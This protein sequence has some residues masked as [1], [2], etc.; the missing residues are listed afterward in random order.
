MLRETHT[1]F[2]SEDFQGNKTLQHL[3]TDKSNIKVGFK[4]IEWEG[5]EWV[6]VLR[7]GTSWV[8]F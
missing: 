7:M 1:Q 3:I 6:V 2:W 4:E 8:P 5:F